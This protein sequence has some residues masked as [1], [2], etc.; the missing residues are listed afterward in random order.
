MTGS[1]SDEAIEARLAAATAE[2]WEALEAVVK[3]VTAEASLATWSGMEPAGTTTIE[4]AERPV[5]RMPSVDYA[6]VVDRLLGCL[7]AVGASVVFDWM[8]W[9]GID[10]L[11]SPGALAA[12]PVADAVRMVTAIRRAERFAEG[13]IAAT[14]EDGILLAAARRLLS[15]H[16]RQPSATAGPAEDAC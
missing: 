6:P 11:R 3:A 8:S 10:R 14:L 15:W 5:Y 2:Q 9:D 1:P 7:A 16:A 13:S 12:A 4:G